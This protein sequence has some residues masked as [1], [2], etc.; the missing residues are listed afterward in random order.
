[1]PLRCDSFA[2]FVT[3]FSAFV[4]VHKRLL[5]FYL[6]AFAGQTTISYKHF[7]AVRVFSHK[8]PTAPSG[9]TTDRIKNVPGCKNGTDLLYHRA[10]YGGVRG[11]RAGCRRKSVMFF[12]RFFA[13][14][15]N[16]TVCDNGYPISGVISKA[17]MVPLHRRRFL[18]CVSKKVH[19]F[20][21]RNN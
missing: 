8:F 21:F 2:Q 11:S 4:R 19:L 12:V 1:M 17:I 9:E 18:H 15:S 14:L 20:A 5:R 10:K 7:P 13:R 16:Y 3:K 6:V